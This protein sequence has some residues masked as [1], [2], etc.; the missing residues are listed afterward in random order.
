MVLDNIQIEILGYALISLA[1][2]PISH[3]KRVRTA[4]LWM[5]YYCTSREQP[6]ETSSLKAYGEPICDPE[7]FGVD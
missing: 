7:D 6:T 2:A 3:T 5:E 4:M 1:E